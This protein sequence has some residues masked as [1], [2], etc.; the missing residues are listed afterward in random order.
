[1]VRIL[2][3]ALMVL[4]AAAGPVHADGRRHN[5]GFHI[6]VGVGIIA[7][8]A[9]SPYP[10]YYQPYYPPYPYAYPYPGYS[11]PALVVEPAP[12]AIYQPA[13]IYV[14]PPATPIQRE[15]IYPT[16]RYELYG[17]GVYAPYK[18]ICKSHQHRRCRQPA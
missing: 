10:Y 15:V 11:P 9:Y 7:P 6:D 5:G 18:S 14:A 13:P 1:M 8:Y 2:V 16:G 12:R 3:L 4:T 17:H